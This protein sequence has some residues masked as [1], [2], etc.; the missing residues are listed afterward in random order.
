MSMRILCICQHMH[1]AVL[2]DSS[3]AIE[4]LLMLA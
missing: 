2:C 4:K 1:H 3:K